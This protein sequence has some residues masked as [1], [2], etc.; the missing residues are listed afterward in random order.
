MIISERLSQK[1]GNR[2]KIQGAAELPAGDIPTA[3]AAAVF[4]R[5]S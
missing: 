1:G 4:D 5:A 2:L 3:A